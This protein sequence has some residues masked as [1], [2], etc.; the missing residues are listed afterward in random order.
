MLIAVIGLGFIAD[1][2][3]GWYQRR[4]VSQHEKSAL[5]LRN[6][7][8]SGLYVELIHVAYEPD[9]KSYRA[10]LNMQNSN[11]EV[12]LYVMLVPAR[13]FV[14]A[15]MIWRE[16][17]SNAQGGSSSSVVKLDGGRQYSVVFQADVK[18]WAELIPGYMHIRIQSDMLISRS[19]E[20]KDDIVERNNRFYVY[21]K[22]Q[23]SDDAQ[24][25]RRSN[26]PGVPPVF[27]PMPPH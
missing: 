9:G 2:G 23:G 15:G 17:P 3:A 26:F 16:L 22:P 6:A 1:S 12:P 7:A 10:T 20:P 13:V 21:L 25:K 27:I 24:I 14:Q 8:F 5:E 19:S 11:P 4:L 18:D